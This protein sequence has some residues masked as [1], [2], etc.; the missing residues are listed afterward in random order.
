MLLL[1]NILIGIQI[2]GVSILFF[3]IGKFIYYE[4]IKDKLMKKQDNY[5]IYR[6]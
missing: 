2:I 1:M 4:C 6:E 3:M 5:S